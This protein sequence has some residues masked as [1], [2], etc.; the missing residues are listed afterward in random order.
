ME[1]H[2]NRAC[3]KH[4]TSKPHVLA[5]QKMMSYR[6]SHAPNSRGTVLN[7][8][9]GDAYNVAFI[10]RNRKHVKVVIDIVMLCAKNDIPLRGHRETAESLNKGTFLELFKLI[11]KYDPEVQTRLD[12]MK[13]NAT[14]MSP[15]IQNELL[16][17]AAS[18]LLR[19]IKKEV[20]ESS[21]FCHIRR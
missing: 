18:L 14:L 16:E 2:I 12:E 11:T 21:H 10:E 6:E 5:Q 19:N 4:D 8:M 20:H 3:I 13:R 9:H 1:I 17:C 15:E 7:Q